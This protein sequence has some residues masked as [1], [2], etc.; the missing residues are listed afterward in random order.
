[1]WAADPGLTAGGVLVGL[2]VLVAAV[3]VTG[4]RRTEGWLIRSGLRVPLLPVTGA[5]VV[6]FALH[7][8]VVDAV[9]DGSA[10]SVFDVPVY[11]W[12]LGHRTGALNALMELVSTA[13]GFAGMAILATIG[14]ALLV[15]AERWPHAVIVVLALAGGELLSNGFKLLYARDRPAVADQ[16]VVTGSYA[17]PSGHSLESTVVLGVLAAVGVLLVRSRIRRSGIVGVAMA[18]VLL[19]GVSRLYLGVHWLTDVLSGY[20]LGGA[21]LAVCVGSLVVLERRHNAESVTNP[22][23]T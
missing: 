3:L 21:Y 1:M 12:L 16:L 5:A 11:S 15:H 22:T 23:P 13:G 9:E 17:L 20:L 6:L 8:A 18:T 14:A 19:I 10:V 4:R 7:I 2:W